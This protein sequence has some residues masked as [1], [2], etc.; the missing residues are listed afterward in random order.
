MLLLLLLHA[1]TA[2]R[3]LVALR[4]NLHE[5]SVQFCNKASLQVQKWWCLL[6][7]RCC[8][9]WPECNVCAQSDVFSAGCV[10]A[11]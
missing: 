10:A 3:R 6:A 1:L 4:W 8:A 7:V 9:L 11:G 2:C 5:T